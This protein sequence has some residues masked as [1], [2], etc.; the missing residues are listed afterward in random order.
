MS[1]DKSSLGGLKVFFW[2]KIV[3]VLL[4]IKGLSLLTEVYTLLELMFGD[5]HLG[6]DSLD[7]Y[8]FVC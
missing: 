6:D 7:A 3:R 8:E 1:L 4:D 5:V 2:V